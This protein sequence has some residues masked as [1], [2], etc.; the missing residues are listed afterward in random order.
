[1]SAWA[2]F[3]QAVFGDPYM[4]WHDGADFSALTR[5]ARS[6]PERV[7]EMLRAG[8]G[9][10][11]PV[12][13]QSVATLAAEGVAPQ[14]FQAVLT[15]ALP[16]AVGSFRVDVA[17]ALAALTGDQAWAREILPVLL[18]GSFWGERLDAA[19]ALARFTPTPELVDAL[20]RAVTDEEYLVRY[21]ASATLL[22]YAGQG[23]E[24]TDHPE[25]FSRI[26]GDEAG[27]A[28]GRYE[29][30]ALLTDLVARSISGPAG[31]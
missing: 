16:A 11:D 10:Q 15:G 7:A 1:M 17:C 27:D 26:T 29:A 5:L 18:G 23:G 30:A 12:A 13:A 4:V 24:L 22:R 2:D 9:E 8:I 3:R 25:V 14:G 20:A 31:P 21:H 19:M 6:E 28:A